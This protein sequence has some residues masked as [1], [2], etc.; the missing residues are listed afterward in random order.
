MNS[1]VGSTKLEKLWPKNRL[2]LTTRQ[3]ADL[4]ISSAALTAAS[5]SGRVLRLRPGAFVLAQ[6]WREMLPSNRDRVR[7]AAHVLTVK[8][9]PTYSHVS[10]ALLH[11]L[12]IWQ[13]GPKVH[14]TAPFARS[15][16]GVPAD[17]HFHRELLSADHVEETILKSGLLA[18]I[19]T[20]ERTVFD[21]ARTLPFESA[22]ILGDS[23]SR[24]GCNMALVWEMAN[25]MTGRRGVARSRK[26]LLAINGLS[27]SP[28]E[29]RTRLII[30]QMPIEQPE[31]QAELLATG[32]LYRPD[33]LWR[34]YKLIVEFDGDIKYFAYKS[35]PEALVQER[36]RE[37]RLMEEGWRFVRLTWADLSEP[38]LVKLRILKAI[39]EGSAEDGGL[40]RN[41]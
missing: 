29:T 10:A 12:S 32:F 15:G 27:E 35:T 18:R 33:F 9:I 8:G 17:V 41:R 2:V 7:L 37:R 11:G 30:A 21:C 13:G 23:A 16:S 5:R 39:A 20:L 26:V 1:G 25:S 24:N 3:L 38:D 31:L 4:G 36:K 34:R 6:A 19:T 22:V 28:G 40:R 14:V